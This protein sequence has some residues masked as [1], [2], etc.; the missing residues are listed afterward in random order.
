MTRYSAILNAVENEMQTDL[1]NSDMRKLARM[2]LTGMHKWKISQT[3]IVGS[4]GL[5]PC[6]SMGNQNLSCVFP[7][8]QTVEEAKQLIHDTMYP[9]DNTKEET[10]Q[11]TE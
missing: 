7:D 2:Q 8:E 5:A 3:N 10:T 9:V 4:T 11:E 1:K 6:F